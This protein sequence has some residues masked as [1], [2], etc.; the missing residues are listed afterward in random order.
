MENIQ[1]GKQ[2]DTFEELDFAIKAYQRKNCVN[3]YK[4]EART[5]EI[6]RRRA[7]NKNFK[8]DLKYGEIAYACVKNGKHKQRL[9]TGERANNATTIRGDCNFIIKCRVTA[10]GQSLCITHMINEHTHPLSETE[11]NNY[12]T[13][14]RMDSETV[15]KIQSEL[16]R[17]ANPKLLQLHYEEQTGKPIKMKD[18]H[19]I[20]QK[21]KH[22]L[23]C[24]DTNQVKSLAD[25]LHKE[26]K[27]LDIEFVL[28]EDNEVSG[29]YIQDTQMKSTFSRF[30]ELIFADST[31]KTNYQNMPL[32]FYNE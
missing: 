31:H 14:K 27:S 5:I 16:S 3:L 2:F 10:D 8:E 1:A 18:I 21:T 32:F 19:N 28:T 17:G 24:G 29:I 25:F 22:T 20:A 9:T 26:Y 4:K 6:A 13:E 23:D 12:P 11:F 7:P 15:T 30:P